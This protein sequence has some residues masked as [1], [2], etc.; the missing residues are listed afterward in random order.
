MRGILFARHDPDVL[1]PH[2][3]NHPP[4]RLADHGPPPRE[5]EELLG[6]AHAALGP[7]PGSRSA[8]HDDDVIHVMFDL[9]GRAVPPPK[10]PPL[11]RRGLR[12]EY[13]RAAGTQ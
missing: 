12:I 9:R 6:K 1:L 11:A 5:V 2:E 4:D 3:G 7:E 10:K 13:L 8:R